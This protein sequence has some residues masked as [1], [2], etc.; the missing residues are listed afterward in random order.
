MQDREKAIAELNARLIA[1]NHEITALGW[2]IKAA[3]T[4]MEQER[5]QKC[6]Q[7]KYVEVN[8]VSMALQLAYATGR[9]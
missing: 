8:K 7:S 4:P 6:C 3:A 2:Q 9:V 1:L 5:L